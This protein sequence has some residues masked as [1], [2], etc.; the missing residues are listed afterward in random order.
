MAAWLAARPWARAE[1]LSFYGGDR[2]VARLR[3]LRPDLRTMSRSSAKTCA[4]GY[5]LA[6]WTGYVPAACR[7]TIVFAPHN[8]AWLAWGWPNRFLA[9]LRA[10][11]S[12]VYLIGEIG[13]RNTHLDALD[14][15]EALHAIPPGWRGGVAT[16]RIEVTGPL[17]KG[18]RHPQA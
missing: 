5:L 13:G 15:P 2:P 1:R 4:T 8:W 18:R 3:Q 17:L 14:T 12:D 9:R 11:G 6:G 10:A 7:R 16:D